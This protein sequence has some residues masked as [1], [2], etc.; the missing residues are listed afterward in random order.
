MFEYQPSDASLVYSP[1]QAR[2][3]ATV[4]NAPDKRFTQVGVVYHICGRLCNICDTDA[5][6][7]TGSVGSSRSLMYKDKQ[8]NKK[9]EESGRNQPRLNPM[10]NISKHEAMPL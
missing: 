2:G 9:G 5:P 6:P 4:Y 3:H 1:I 10:V 8:M 7:N